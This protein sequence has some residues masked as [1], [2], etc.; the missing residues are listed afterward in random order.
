MSDQEH[1][2]AWKVQYA[3]NRRA[4]M[5]VNPEYAAK[6]KS[7]RSRTVEEN[8]LYMAEYYRNNPDKFK[9]NNHNNEKRNIDRRNPK[10]FAKIERKA[11]E[12]KLH[13]ALI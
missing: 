9:R 6:R 2:M 10:A 4:K 11:I 5:A 8:K 7:V 3:K 13:L 12:L 1:K